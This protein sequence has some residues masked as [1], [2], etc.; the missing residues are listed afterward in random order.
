M[1]VSL[2][3][4]IAWN[5]GFRGILVVAVG[6][7]VLMGSVFLL[8]ATN[9]GA[10]FCAWRGPGTSFV[11]SAFAVV[12]TSAGCQLRPSASAAVTSSCAPRAWASRST[13]PPRSCRTFA[14]ASSKARCS[15][16]TISS[17]ARSRGSTTDLS[18]A[19]VSAAGGPPSRKNQRSE[20]RSSTVASSGR[21]GRR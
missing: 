19:S 6:V 15:S 8:L 17:C 1:N 18:S 14:R 5:P 3:A 12:E 9:S 2:L 10:R 7:I 16:R 4:Q 20:S 21:S 13:P 11:S